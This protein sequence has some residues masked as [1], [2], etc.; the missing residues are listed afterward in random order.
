[1]FENGKLNKI[2]FNLLCFYF[3]F[4]VLDTSIL[5]GI[6]KKEKQNK[7]QRQHRKEK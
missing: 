7:K 3:W 1:M 2:S 5:E 6:H 4:S